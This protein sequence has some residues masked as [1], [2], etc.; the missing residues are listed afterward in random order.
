MSNKQPP[1]PGGER[2]PVGKSEAGDAIPVVQDEDL[3]W[4]RCEFL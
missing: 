1:L 4:N 3:S 2:L